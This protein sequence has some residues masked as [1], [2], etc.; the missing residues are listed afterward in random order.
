MTWSRTEVGGAS[1]PL[2]VSRLM[3]GRSC[4]STTFA[5][6]VLC[7]TVGVAARYKFIHAPE[8]DPAGTWWDYATSGALTLFALWLFTIKMVYLNRKRRRSVLAGDHDCSR[9][10]CAF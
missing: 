10:F 1:A 3:I 9:E 7:A 2:R 6:L 5:T 8:S 4:S